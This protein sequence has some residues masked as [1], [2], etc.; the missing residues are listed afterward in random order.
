MIIASAN[1]LYGMCLHQSRVGVKSIKVRRPRC[2][3]KESPLQ[4]AIR[5][6]S[7]NALPAINAAPV[8]RPRCCSKEIPLQSAIPEP[9]MNALLYS[10]RLQ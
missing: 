1:V 4:F 8:R 2:C 10:A 6:P 5:K 3:S 7:I 9:S